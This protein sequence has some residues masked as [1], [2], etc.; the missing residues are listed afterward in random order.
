MEKLFTIIFLL[1]NYVSYGQV[2]I[3]TEIKCGTT[4]KKAQ[5]YFEAG[6]AGLQLN[7]LVEAERLF[8]A[9]TREDTMFCD[10]WDHLSICCRRQ[11]HYKDAFFAGINSLVIDSINA[12]AWTNCGYAAFL[13]SNMDDAII[14]F[15]H[16]QRIIPDNPEGYYGMSMVLYSMNEI[17]D[18]RDNI[19]LAKEKYK[20]KNTQIGL[21]VDLLHGF[22]EYKYGDL[23]A[24]QDLFQKVYSKFKYNAD[25]NYYLGECIMVNERNIKKSKSYKD[26]AIK[27]GFKEEYPEIPLN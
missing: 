24:A 7:R 22:I 2:T 21:E 10:A 16:L 13:N 1:I 14:S 9:A 19:L 15:E 8:Y 26:K 23:R 3:Q 11:G 12:V 18:S 6:N 27:L 4:N 20:L 25:L 17:K 5:E